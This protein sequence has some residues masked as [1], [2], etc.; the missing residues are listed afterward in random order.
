[1]RISLPVRRRRHEAE[2][3][4][5]WRRRGIS[6][7]EWRSQGTLTPQAERQLRD[8]R[9]QT[10]HPAPDVAGD[11]TYAEISAAQLAAYRDAAAAADFP[12]RSGFNPKTGSADTKPM[13]RLREMPRRVP[14]AT[15]PPVSGTVPRAVAD[16]ATLRLVL[17]G[18]EA[19]PGTTS[20]RGPGIGVGDYMDANFI[21]PAPR[22][23]R[24][25]E[26][27]RLF[28]VNALAYPPCDVTAPD[29]AAAYIT[30]MRQLDR[31]TGTQGRNRWVLPALPSGGA[32]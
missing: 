11:R 5:D 30:L 29:H 20:A 26:V 10:V 28:R 24:R 4:A 1:M 16:P 13:Q 22:H 32:A 9:A 21:H 6:D 15:R 23:P 17:D 8:S 2:R 19:L 7:A 3:L 25:G 14:G 27:N 31:I 12:A 18:L